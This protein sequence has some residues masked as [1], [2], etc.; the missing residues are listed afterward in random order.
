[1]ADPKIPAFN[2]HHTLNLPP[3]TDAP[4]P[5]AKKDTKPA[6]TAVV[7]TPVKAEVKANAKADP[8]A[9]AK[10]RKDLESFAAKL[11][12][13]LKPTVFILASQDGAPTKRI[14]V[15]GEP[16][17]VVSKESPPRI[18][19]TIKARAKASITPQEKQEIAAKYSR[20]LGAT[21]QTKYKIGPGH[22][23]FRLD[24]VQ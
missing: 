10:M 6:A 20:D 11:P 17:C 19:V 4:A 13:N 24:I 18:T 2:T 12:E 8:K 16:V 7:K 1:M 22:G 9:E 14:E 3:A 21:L 5:A 23:S 15:I